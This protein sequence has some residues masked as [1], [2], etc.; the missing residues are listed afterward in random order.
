MAFL[1]QV[2]IFLKVF[3]ITVSRILHHSREMLLIQFPVDM[4]GQMSSIDKNI[5]YEGFPTDVFLTFLIHVA[6]SSQRL[7]LCPM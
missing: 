3:T 7:Y 1:V 4:F 2:F 6:T 5:F